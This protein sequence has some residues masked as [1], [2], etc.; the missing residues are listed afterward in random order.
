VGDEGRFRKIKADTCKKA[1]K[2]KGKGRRNH[3][4]N[5]SD[6]VTKRD[7]KIPSDA[8]KKGQKDRGT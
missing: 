6:Y 8:T 3:R 4:P 7:G 2:K 1:K 5:H